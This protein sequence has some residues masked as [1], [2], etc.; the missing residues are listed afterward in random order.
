MLDLA[1]HCYGSLYVFIGPRCDFWLV[2]WSPPGK[3]K[4]HG[5]LE[6]VTHLATVLYREL[7]GITICEFALDCVCIRT[8][9]NL[10]PTL[11]RQVLDF[12]IGENAIAEIPLSVKVPHLR[13]SLV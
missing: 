4:H 9:A 5:I 1:G 2:A 11:R 12:G 6:L 8:A 7:Q 3:P 10:P 13:R